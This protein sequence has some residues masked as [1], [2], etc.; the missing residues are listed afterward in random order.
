M[1]TL[2]IS[3]HSSAPRKARE[4]WKIRNELQLLI[5][6]ILIFFKLPIFSFSCEN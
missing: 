1:H 3:L 4:Q 5:D 6:N 2:Q